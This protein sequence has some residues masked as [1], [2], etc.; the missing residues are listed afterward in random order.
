MH[1]LTIMYKDTERENDH[2]HAFGLEQALELYQ[3]YAQRSD[4]RAVTMT[5]TTQTED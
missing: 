1:R 2:R 5:Y 3:S 4:V